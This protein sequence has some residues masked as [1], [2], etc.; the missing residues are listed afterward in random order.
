MLVRR[1]FA[2]AVACAAMPVALCSCGSDS[3]PSSNP[4][5]DAG[6][7]DAVHTEDGAADAGSDGAQ[8]DGDLS[9]A[10]QTDGGT[11]DAPQSDAGFISQCDY[12]AAIASAICD[13][14]G[15]CCAAHGYEN[16]VQGCR[17]HIL[18]TFQDLMDA[19]ASSAGVT[20]D[21]KAAADC[22]EQYKAYVL[23]CIPDQGDTDALNA[24]C[25]KVVVGTT[26]DG[27]PCTN[28]FECAAAA[29][30][31]A[32]CSDESDADGG[33][34][35]QCEQASGTL[36]HGSV[37]ATCSESC[38]FMT[39]SHTTC[40]RVGEYVE[41]QATCWVED[42]LRCDVATHT[43]VAVQALGASCD[44]DTDCQASAYCE[45]SVCAALPTDSQACDPDLPIPCTS[46]SYCDSISMVCAPNKK[47]GDACSDSLE[48]ESWQCH[49][50]TCQPTDLIATYFCI[51]S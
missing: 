45:T 33:S 12:P 37:G 11:C 34:Y 35:R 49:A 46:K 39:G 15:A 51:E 30:G 31:G 23:K 41:A 19:M 3:A 38:R 18:G 2:L 29:T 40:D 7:P 48:C 6:E 4:A 9:D 44:S 42:G 10:V 5:T 36:P 17:D 21:A 20:Y 14:V 8:A 1:K 24:V 28:Y 26:Q 25:N 13:N 16:S 22:V 50:G 32:V 27:Q 43:C 47:T